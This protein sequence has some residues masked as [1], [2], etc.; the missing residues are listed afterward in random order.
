M[1]GADA[2]PKRR[3][4]AA[5]F[6]VLG[7]PITLYSH[8]PRALAAFRKLYGRM[9]EADHSPDA[10]DALQV[11]IRGREGA[12]E[13]RAVEIEEHP[14]KTLGRA[15]QSAETSCCNFALRAARELVTVHAATV[16]FGDGLALITGDSGAG[17]TT[18]TLTLAARGRPIDGDDVAMLDPETGLVHGLPRC[19][20]LDDR[21]I[22]LL[23]DQGLDV[24]AKE[25]L[26]N[27][28]TPADVGDAGMEARPVRALFMLRSA[29]LAEPQVRRRPLAEAVALLDG[30]TGPR[31]RPSSQLF[32]DFSRML[33]GADF[34]EVRRGPLGATADQ[35][36]EIM[37]E[38]GP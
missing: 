14:R 30:Q 7:A 15:L 28:F 38:L 34:F 36:G 16:R 25:S 9:P 10:P 26:K 22:E 32:Q 18:L 2:L 21:S 37:G 20:H 27:F 1:T 35:I 11:E 13:A 12:W 4:E 8:E 33:A 29:D 31:Y 5:R 19:F 24:R 17:K 3:V 23:A 6:S